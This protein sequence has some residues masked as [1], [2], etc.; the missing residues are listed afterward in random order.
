MPAGI[1][2]HE[3]PDDLAA[4]DRVE[5]GDAGVEHA[6]LGEQLGDA[7]GVATVEVVAVAGEQVADGGAVFG[8]RRH[9][10]VLAGHA[11]ATATDEHDVNTTTL[12]RDR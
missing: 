2:S 7:V 6:V 12:V 9:A 1:G 10:L 11:S 4:L 3:A 8:D 5:P